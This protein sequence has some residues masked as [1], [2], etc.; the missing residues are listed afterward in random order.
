MSLWAA[1]CILFHYGAKSLQLNAESMFS[2]SLT[3]QDSMLFGTP[4]FLA[5]AVF[6]IWSVFTSG[7]I[8]ISTESWRG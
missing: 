3:M 6:E 1:V 2:A 5:M 8:F 7:I 4:N